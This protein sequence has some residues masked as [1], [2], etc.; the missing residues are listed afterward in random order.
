M[1]VS[2]VYR[3]RSM[4][5]LKR[6]EGRFALYEF[7]HIQGHLLIRMRFLDGGDDAFNRTLLTSD[8]SK[9]CK[10]DFDPL[11]LD[12]FQLAD[13]ADMGHGASLWLESSD[14]AHRKCAI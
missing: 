14:P 11:F 6:P 5:S 8:Y 1:Q 4:S 9:S 7:I 10:A 12:R 13:R 2:G 3:H